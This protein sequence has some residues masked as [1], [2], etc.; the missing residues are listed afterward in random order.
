MSPKFCVFG[1]CA[2]TLAGC[3]GPVPTNQA[4]MLGGQQFT[5]WRTSDQAG[6]YVYYQGQ[7]IACDGSADDCTAQLAAAKPG[8]D[9]DIMLERALDND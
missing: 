4:V 6:H 7:P 5:V 1:L 2:A 9:A 3:A 8:I